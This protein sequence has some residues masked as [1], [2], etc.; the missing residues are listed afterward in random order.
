MSGKVFVLG[1]FVADC[2]FRTSRLPVVGETLLGSSFVL[3][4]GGKGSNQA[5]AA[6]RAGAEVT[7]LSSIANDNFGEIGRNLWAEEKIDGSLVVISSEPTGSAAIL[8]DVTSGEN[9]IIVV[10]GACLTLLA[11][12]V[13]RAAAAIGR[14]RVFLTQ[15]EVPVPA[16]QRGLEIA[17]K[18]GVTTIVN[19]AP[20]PADQ[21]APEFL[22]LVDYLVPNETEAERLTG[23]PCRTPQE[24]EVCAHA[25]HSAGARNVIITMGASG[26]L[27][28]TQ[29]A[30][31]WVR[32]YVAGQVIDT[33]GAGDAFCGA[34][35]AGLSAGMEP[36]DAAQFAAAGAAICVTR[37]GTATSMALKEDIEAL[38][39][40]ERV[41]QR[42]DPGD[43]RTQS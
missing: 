32:P 23:M 15:F 43:S 5:V 14:A 34:F 3:G 30:L 29:S 42:D 2:A 40:A 12:D 16:I 20:A 17:R 31:H 27:L 41:K 9:S 39:R 8:I 25:L 1:S 13:E 18:A 22:R 33:T 6:A 21:L 26:A 4:P 36:L 7:I 24:A 38:L 28:L 35:A 19:P 37:N 10:P 11:S